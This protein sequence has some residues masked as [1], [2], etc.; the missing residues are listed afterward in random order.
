MRTATPHQNIHPGFI[1]AYF[2]H[3]GDLDFKDDNPDLLAIREASRKVPVIVSIY[4]ERPAILTNMQPLTAALIGNF[5][6]SD[7]ALLNVI[8]GKARPQGRLPFELPSSMEAVRQQ[9]EDVPHDSAN[10]LFRY[11]F[12]LTYR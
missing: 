8:T 5:G 6:A 10:P 12:G 7:Q 11:G 1:G 2:L 9:K 4:L 3:E